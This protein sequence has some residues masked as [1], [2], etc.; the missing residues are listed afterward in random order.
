MADLLV[1][2]PDLP[3]AP[4]ELRDAGYGCAIAASFRKNAGAVALAGSAPGAYKN[5][6]K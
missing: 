4:E 5:P 1:K 3:G 2:L 6:V